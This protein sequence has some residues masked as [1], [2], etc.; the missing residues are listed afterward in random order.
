MLD[1]I[2]YLT[3]AVV[4][5]LALVIFLATGPIRNGQSGKEPKSPMLEA[6]VSFSSLPQWHEDWESPDPLRGKKGWE[7]RDYINIAVAVCLVLMSITLLVPAISMA[8]EV[9]RRTMVL[10]RMVEVQFEF[11]ER[12]AIP[13][14]PQFP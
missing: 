12:M 4:Y 1:Q 14:N 10:H 2:A 9:E 11:H 8:R 7:V 3:V 6:E 5:A 13:V